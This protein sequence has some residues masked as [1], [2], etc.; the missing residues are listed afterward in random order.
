MIREL[1]KIITLQIEILQ[2]YK[3][4]NEKLHVCERPRA[5]KADRFKVN[6]WTTM[7][8]NESVWC[9]KYAYWN[10]NIAPCTDKKLRTKS[11][12]TDWGQTYRLIGRDMDRQRKNRHEMIIWPS[13]FYCFLNTRVIFTIVGLILLNF[14]TEYSAKFVDSNHGH[15]QAAGAQTQGCPW[16]P[17]TVHCGL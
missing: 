4:L 7:M 2:K 10:G 8:S 3:K 16:K 9:K 6:K 13:G 12:L 1:T 15:S 17:K 5:I 14:S 11:K